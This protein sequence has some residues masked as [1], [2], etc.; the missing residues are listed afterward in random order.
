MANNTTKLKT[1]LEKCAHHQSIATENSSAQLHF[2]K[3]RYIDSLTYV[4]AE[5]QRSFEAKLSA[6]I[7]GDGIPLSI[8]ESSLFQAFVSFMNP[9][10]KM[11]CRKTLSNN[12]LTENYNHALKTIQTA[13]QDAPSLSL[14]FDAWTDVCHQPVIATPRPFFV[15]CFTLCILDISS[16]LALTNLLLS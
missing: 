4:T 2:S 13:I 10:Y 5:D 14:I 16:S 6:Y 11:P 8:V 12:I 3:R 7:F 15:Y 1:H 9:Y